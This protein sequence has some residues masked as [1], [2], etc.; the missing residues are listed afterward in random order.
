MQ[1]SGELQTTF[2]RG[3][4]WLTRP[5]MMSIVAMKKPHRNGRI[6]LRVP[7]IET[8]SAIKD[9]VSR[10]ANEKRHVRLSDMISG[11]DQD[12]IQLLSTG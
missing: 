10:Q 6:A 12:L 5:T 2:H 11:K 9:P 4:L 1:A 8:A 3:V 7:G